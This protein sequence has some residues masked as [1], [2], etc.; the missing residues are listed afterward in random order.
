[1]KA[2]PRTR[3][4]RALTALTILALLATAFVSTQYRLPGSGPTNAYASRPVFGTDTTVL[5]YLSSSCAA[6]TRQPE[7]DLLAGA[8]RRFV[9]VT[10]RPRLVGVSI[11]LNAA[12]G[13]DYLQELVAFDEISAGGGWNNEL[14][15]RYLFPDELPPM[16]NVPQLVMVE[17]KLTMTEG[18]PATASV[19]INV[20]HRLMGL[21]P[22]TDWMSRQADSRRQNPK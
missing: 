21:R 17:R 10:R 11:D 19:E 14:S 22:I 13:A 6:C 8:L 12:A 15:I 18:R 16:A 3:V 9:S 4:E 2:I 7:A 20:V 5:I 1:M